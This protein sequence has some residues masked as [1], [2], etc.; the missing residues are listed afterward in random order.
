MAS[1]DRLHIKKKGRL[2]FLTPLI[3]GSLH[4]WSH[5]TFITTLNVWSSR[6][7]R[8]NWKL[9]KANTFSQSQVSV[10]NGITLVWFL[11]EVTTESWKPLPITT[12]SLL[13]KLECAF[14]KG[15]YETR[16]FTLWIWMG[17]N[18]FQFFQCLRKWQWWWSTNHTLKGK[19]DWTTFS[20]SIFPRLIR[21]V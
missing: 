3:I 19:V 13:L 12:G 17:S 16:V 9:R 14:S 4:I 2:G 21:N 5:F 6:C 7:L 15:V 8:W 1:Q 10:R 18:G 20:S 11:F